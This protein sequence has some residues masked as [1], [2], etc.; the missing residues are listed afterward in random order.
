MS[1]RVSSRKKVNYSRY[2]EDADNFGSDDDF[3]DSPNPPQSKKTKSNENRNKGKDKKTKE[4]KQT[5]ILSKDCQAISSNSRKSRDE[6]IFEKEL[7]AALELSKKDS[8]E[9][10]VIEKG[11]SSS[12]NVEVKTE[13]KRIEEQSKNEVVSEPK[14]VA[15]DE[16]DGSEEY[17]LSDDSEDDEEDGYEEHDNDDDDDEFVM[18]RKKV[19]K[20][21]K[22][23]GMKSTE[24]ESDKCLPPR[25]N[26]K[27][28][29][30]K[31][32]KPANKTLTKLSNA[33]SV[34]NTS[35]NTPPLRS[36]TI[37]TRVAPR[38]GLKSPAVIMK[39]AITQPP[40]PGNSPM[41]SL[42]NRS[43]Y[44]NASPA[45]GGIM[46]DSSRPSGLRLGL[47]RNV[48]VAKPLHSN[49]AIK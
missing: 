42:Q 11:D 29:E 3:Q 47:S 6:K 25:K 4:K 7:Q 16:L 36:S 23:D 33:T 8:P 24:K 13:E 49:I 39:N 44:G 21:D 40:S 34:T 1:R 46:N 20:K 48:R 14:E 2:M 18:E 45:V 17:E 5:S 9:V 43:K 12:E 27:E 22:G 30:S 31:K 26:Q 32:A 37:Q 10:I 19:V 15:G 41:H 28:K 38:V 35:A